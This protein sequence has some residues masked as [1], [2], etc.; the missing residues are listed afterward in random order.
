[1][2]TLTQVLEILKTD[3]NFREIIADGQYFYSWD[4]DV[5][6]SELSYDSRKVTEQTLFFAKGLSFKKEYLENFA[7]S[8]YISEIDYE[9]NIPALIVSDVK[10][11]MSLIA[12]AFYGNPQKKLK[13]L[14]LT[15]TKGK[16]TSAYFA[17]SILDQMNGGR[18]A[19][20]STAETTLDG[21]TFFKSELTTPESLDLLEMME[22][23][24]KNGMTHLVME[25][26][27][28]AYKMERVYGVTFDVGVFLNFSPDHIGPLE[29]PTMEDYFYCKR[30]LMHNSKFVVINSEMEHFNLLKEES[31]NIPHAYYGNHSE[32]KIVNSHALNF[33]TV[34]TITEDFSIQLLGKFNQE[35]A[36]ATALATQQ[37]GASIEHIKAGL[38]QATVPGRMETFSTSTGTK[39]Y[40]DYAHN[41]V[42]LENLVSVVE[43][44]HKG[45][46]ILIL[47]ATGNKGESRR[48][49][50]GNVIQAHPRLEVILTQDDSNRENPITIAQ[51][52]ASY[53]TRPVD[54]EADREKAIEK[55][56]ALAASPN[57]AIIIAG[58]GADKFQLING[59]RVP[60][61]GDAELAQKYM[62]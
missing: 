25:V 13:T 51:E 2:I 39:I 30:Q 41:G 27:S 24:L 3:E 33:S 36:L 6:F 37:L 16:T 15:G 1:M 19:L 59:E 14:A 40:I 53:I 18:T 11:A 43:P 8:F 57:D 12:Q 50:F 5:T 46:V 42:S 26:S 29:H 32:N 10:K 34:G 35:N 21:T 49:D 7:S 44:H 58:K 23:A 17:K 52:I 54:I 31:K 28:Q 20:L 45:K 56:I 48:K 62:K 38:A 60:Y 55:A 47:G 4:S 22:Q 61:M 9:V